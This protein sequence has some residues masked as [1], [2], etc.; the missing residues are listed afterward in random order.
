MLT[1]SSPPPPTGYENNRRP[2]TN[3]EPDDKLL[4]PTAV[5]VVGRLR[6]LDMRGSGDPLDTHGHGSMIKPAELI[7]VVEI[8]ALNRSELLLYNQLI[9]HAWNNLETARVH[10]IQKSILRGS[11]ESNDRLH[12]AFDRLMGAFAKIRHRHPETGRAMTTRVGLLGPNTE[13]EAEDGYFYYSFNDTLLK[14]LHHSRSWARLKTD[15]M[16]L[17]RSKYALRLYEI[18]ERRINMNAQ[19][20][21]FTVDELR[22]LLGVPD[23]KLTRFSDFNKYA[24]KPAI[25]EINTLTDY[26]VAIA[27]RKR[28]RA[29]HQLILIWNRKPAEEVKDAISRRQQTRGRHS[30]CR[31]SKVELIA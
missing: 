19:S 11:H 24:L 13:E 28:G 12:E 26:T 23:D 21:T 10:R 25:D 1:P 4:T 18:I 17:L 14:I 2:V 29:V 8:S 16:Y 7:D 30:A 20:E 5:R 6:T 3:P 27:V 15:I 22:A 31:V 9:A